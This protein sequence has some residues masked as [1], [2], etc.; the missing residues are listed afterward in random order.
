MF[1]IISFALFLH[2]FTVSAECP[3]DDPSYRN[4]MN[5]NCEKMSHVGYTTEEVTELLE[6]C[7][8]SCG[9]C[10]KART[11]PVQECHD[12]PTY[13]DTFGMPCIRYVETNC[14][15]TRWIGF[16]DEE[17]EELMEKCPVSCGKCRTVVITTSAPSNSPSQS[18]SVYPIQKD[19]VCEDDPTYLDEYELVCTDYLYVVCAMMG[20]AKYSQ[21]QV[22]ELQT[23]CRKSCGTCE[24]SPSSSPTDFTNAPTTAFVQIS[25]ANPTQVRDEIIVDIEPPI[26]VRDVEPNFFVDVVDPT[27]P[28]V[29]QPPYD[30]PTVRYFDGYHIAFDPFPGEGYKVNVMTTAIAGVALLILSIMFSLWIRKKVVQHKRRK[31][32]RTLSEEESVSSF[33]FEDER[34]KEV[35]NVVEQ[36]VFFESQPITPDE[37]NNA[38]SDFS[39]DIDVEEEDLIDATVSDDPIWAPMSTEHQI[40]AAAH[41]SGAIVQPMERRPTIFHSDSDEED[42]NLGRLSPMKYRNDTRSPS[43]P[44]RVSSPVRNFPARN[45]PVRGSR[46]PVRGPGSHARGQ[47]R[48]MPSRVY[49]VV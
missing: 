34:G 7:P 3:D 24:R 39:F 45:S 44:V 31:L 13:R 14:E 25:S 46:S 40:Q 21:R 4:P 41:L 32:D 10:S 20:E 12:N 42:E 30:E 16:T 18:P 22:N 5:T 37:E 9:Q 17:V 2:Q 29:I 47:P 49:P 6:R 36:K 28:E 35:A 23:R 33:E 11:S 8:K 19:P 15:Y 26:E 43:P 38:R 48:K 1:S 27:I